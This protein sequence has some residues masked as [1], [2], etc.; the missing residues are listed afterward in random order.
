LGA[1]VNFGISILGAGFGAGAATTTG[2]G[3]L[4]VGAAA[5]EAD[6]LG[7]GAVALPLAKD[8]FVTVDSEAAVNATIAKYDIFFILLPLYSFLI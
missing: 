8:E 6:A 7:A 2:A 5:L 1:G 3:G 4:G